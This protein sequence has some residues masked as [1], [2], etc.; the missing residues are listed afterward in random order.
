MLLYIK[1][2]NNI[3]SIRMILF[4]EKTFTD[5]IIGYFADKNM[6]S[7]IL[8]LVDL[9]WE[10]LDETEKQMAVSLLKKNCQVV[11]RSKLSQKILDEQIAGTL[12]VS[13]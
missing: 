10:K 6:G 5:Q 8:R 13:M 2:L 12:T 11:I 7:R 4:S 9:N 1:F 3:K